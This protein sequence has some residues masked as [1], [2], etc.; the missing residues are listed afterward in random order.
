MRPR[1]LYKY[2]SN[3]EHAESFCN[4]S[5]LFRSLAY[6][7]DY[8]DN[9]IRED[10]NEGASAYRPNDGLLV[11]NQTR[12]TQFILKGHSFVSTVKHE[13]IFVF[14]LSG[15]FESSLFKTFDAMACVEVLDIGAF[16]ARIE[17]S[18]PPK[19]SLPETQTS[20]R[21]RIGHWVEYYDE[22]ENCTPRWALPERIATSKLRSYAWQ[23]EF[24]LLF[25]T[26]DAFE[27]EK[28][29]LGLVPDG[30]REVINTEQHHH[31]VLKAGSLRDIC[32]LYSCPP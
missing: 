31:C 11:T 32:R 23:R 9:N 4:G 15:V 5:L 21:R 1:R 19:A 26:T 24:R 3:M 14:C 22:A 12:G 25:S 7:R 8:E 10:K 27:F 13:E 30:H 16:C 20:R 28:V 18:L 17:A 29:A 6:F 2:F